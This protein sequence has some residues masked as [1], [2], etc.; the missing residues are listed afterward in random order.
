MDGSGGAGMDFTSFPDL[1]QA[2]IATANAA[3]QAVQAASAASSSA[4][5]AGG[6]GSEVVKKDLAKLIPRPGVFNP[7]G[8]EQEILQW[9]DWYWC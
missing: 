4:G 1:T 6:E 7:S 8:R 3:T 9:R 5:Q 2:L